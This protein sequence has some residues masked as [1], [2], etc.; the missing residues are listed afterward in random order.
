MKNRKTLTVLVIIAVI[1]LISI[2]SS[3]AIFYSI[4]N[5][6]VFVELP[7]ETVQ[8]TCYI[9]ETATPLASPSPTATPLPE[10]P[11]YI[12]YIIGDGMGYSHLLLG[13]AYEKIYNG[14]FSY[15]PNWELFEMQKECIP[16]RE[17]AGGG[18]MLATGYNGEMDKVAVD[19][20][21]RELVTI[22]D[23]AKDAG[24]STGVISNSYINDATPATF[25]A[26]T[27]DR[28][29]YQN[30][31]S[32]IPESGVDFI[33]SGGM[34]YFM[35]DSGK[36]LYGSRDICGYKYSF[37]GEDGRIDNYQMSGYTTLLGADAADFINQTQPQSYELD[38][39][40]MLFVAKNMSYQRTK[41]GSRMKDMETHEPDLDELTQAGI[42]FLSK[43][44]NGFM[45]VIEEALIDKASHNNWMEITSAEMHMMNKTLET[46]FEF[47][48]EHPYETL[49]VFT[50]DHETGDMTYNTEFADI[51]STFE[52][53]D[54]NYTA[55]T[56]YNI[57]KNDWGIDADYS[58]IEDK[59][60]VADLNIWGSYDKNYTLLNCYLA[61][62]LL[63]DNGIKFTSSYHSYQNVPLY[64]KGVKSAL[65][66]ECEYIYDIS[67]IVCEIMEWESL[68][69]IVE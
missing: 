55:D 53:V 13:S 34:N 15:K 3:F 67:P 37:K 8:P 58:K 12:F 62:N 17:S 43:N 4:G 29:E 51:I 46:V 65:F 1:A 31:I 9:R 44:E 5:S 2:I 25:L 64:V 42:E 19:S 48:S 11:K 39:I 60:D 20:Q 22:L 57:A 68:P 6:D 24:M 35:G 7:S 54:L 26:H 49:I 61:A 69:K 66:S 38:K 32:Q 41:Y 23:R 56:I 27:N 21:G 50:A 28:S 33:A 45:L 16:G 63:M 47:Y 18:T 30:I 36:E 10:K 40:F 59:K 52:N 14:D